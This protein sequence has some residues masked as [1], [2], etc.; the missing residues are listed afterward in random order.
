MK[1]YVIDE[2]R[3]DEIAKVVS[4][5]ENHCDQGGLQNI[6]WL[7]IPKEMLSGVQAI[8]ASCGPHCSAVEVHSDRVIFELLVR[9]RKKIRC[10][11]VSYA[12]RPQRDYIID[13]A[14]NLLNTV[15]S[16]A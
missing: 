4:Y 6:F 12:N 5:L 1:Q 2:L 3:P 13:F 15:L 10:E 9:G 14:D 16:D 11:C 8:H 7:E